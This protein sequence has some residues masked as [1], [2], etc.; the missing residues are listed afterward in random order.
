MERFV[1]HDDTE[2]KGFDFGYVKFCFGDYLSLL[3]RLLFGGG[4]L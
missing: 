3:L 4:Q 1:T 2:V